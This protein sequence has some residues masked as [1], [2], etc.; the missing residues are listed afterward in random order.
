M[1]DDILTGRSDLDVQSRQ[2]WSCVVT[3]S[4]AICLA[5]RH[6]TCYTKARA[7]RA[8]GGMGG[9][10]PRKERKNAIG[11]HKWAYEGHT[12][13]QTELNI[14]I[15]F[16]ESSIITGDWGR[17]GGDG[18]LSIAKVCSK[19]TNAGGDKISIIMIFNEK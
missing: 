13:C 11:R 15:K 17:G 3:P 5:I 10:P 14:C 1:Y 4:Y 8:T 18:L 16:W 19:A 9:R 6:P 7:K 2:L 12:N